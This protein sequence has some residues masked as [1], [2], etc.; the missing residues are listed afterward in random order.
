MQQNIKR[1]EPE[2]ETEDD[3]LDDDNIE[4]I[5][6]TFSVNSENYAVATS[7]VTEVVGMQKIVEVPDVPSFIKGVINLRGKIITVMDIRLRFG[8]KPKEYDDRTCIVVLDINEA[9]TGLVVD[10]VNE[11]VEILPKNIDPPVRSSG[12]QSKNNIMLGIGKHKDKVS[13]IIDVK[14]LVFDESKREQSEISENES[15]H[16]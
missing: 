5:Y 4:N 16:S 7:Y 6:L 9:P 14:K 13:V 2:F 12:N 8:I 3:D 10:N 1:A 11:V 15:H